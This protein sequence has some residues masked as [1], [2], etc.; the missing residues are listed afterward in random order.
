MSTQQH[1]SSTDPGSKSA[2]EIER[3][4]EH[5]RAEVERTLD[6]IQDRL[7]PGELVDQAVGYLRTSGG[8]EFTRNLGDS[9]KQNPLPIA[10]V[11][12]GVGWMMLSG[13]RSRRDGEYDPGYRGG[14]DPAY[15]D[16][17]DDDHAGLTRSTYATGAHAAT[18]RSGAG[19]TYSSPGS[20]DSGPSVGDRVSEAARSAGDRASAAGERAGDAAR[21]AG[22]RVSGAARAAGDHLSAA[23]Q[24]TEEKVGDLGDEARRFGRQAQDRLHRTSRDA[25][26]HVSR[27]GSYAR[28][29]G[30]RATQNVMQIVNEQPLLLGALGLAVGAAIGAAAPPTE[31][32]DRWMGETR[33]DALRRAKAAGEDALHRARE[34]GEEAAEKARAVAGAAVDAARDQAKAQGSGSAS[35]SASSATPGQGS[36]KP[37]TGAP[38]SGGERPASQPSAGKPSSA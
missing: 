26:D 28:R 17:D 30:Q 34:A 8:A 23:A 29:G 7:S 11:A 2:A 3:E 15:P 21:A 38:S 13:P 37:T 10:L 19:G 12:V 36:P 6:Q 1:T 24:A 18:Y 9:L 5:S 35:T 4:V 20:T 16:L 32:E 31:T 22:D 33:D 25:A 14:Y 27:A